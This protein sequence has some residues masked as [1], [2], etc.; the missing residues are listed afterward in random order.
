MVV[1]GGTVEEGW[2]RGGRGAARRE[3][4]LMNPAGWILKWLEES[5]IEMGGAGQWRGD[6]GSIWDAS[7][8]SGVK[9]SLGIPTKEYLAVRE[10][11]FKD[12]ETSNRSSS[13]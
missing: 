11:S 10:R 8:Q 1:G 9:E 7:N 6:A 5:W 2:Q 4:A 12:P 13:S 3:S